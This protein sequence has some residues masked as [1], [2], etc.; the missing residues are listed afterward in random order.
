MINQVCD[1]KPAEED[2]PTTC[3]DADW[4]LSTATATT[5]TTAAA[6]ATTTT[7][8]TA[9]TATTAAAATTTAT[10]AKSNGHNQTC[11]GQGI[12]L[13]P[14]LQALRH[15]PVQAWVLVHMDCSGEGP[16]APG[17]RHSAYELI[18]IQPYPGCSVQLGKGCR[19]GASEPIAAEI[20][21]LQVTQCP[22]LL[23]NGSLHKIDRNAVVDREA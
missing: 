20:E 13:Q 15:L 3:A 17:F 19:Q 22:Q 9:T 21:D 8:A 14:A 5:A 12:R 4:S 11:A 18:V 2:I 23:R 7:T 10:A 6:A 1:Q 16:I